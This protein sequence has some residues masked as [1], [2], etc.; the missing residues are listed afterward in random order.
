MTALPRG[1]DFHSVVL[2]A[3][4]NFGGILG[5]GHTG[6]NFLKLKLCTYIIL[7]ILAIIQPLRDIL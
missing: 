4:N 7:S 2:R 5:A 1:P 3:V 6:T